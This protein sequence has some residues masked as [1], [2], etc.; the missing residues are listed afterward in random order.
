MIE[1]TWVPLDSY[2]VGKLRVNH[3]EK[4]KSNK[5]FSFPAGNYVKVI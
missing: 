1:E 4:S 3:D 5:D 2:N